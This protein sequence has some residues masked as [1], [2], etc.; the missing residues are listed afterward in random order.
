MDFDED[1]STQRFLALL[2]PVQGRIFAYILSRWPNMADAQDLM[3]ESIATMWEK[4][5]E[6]TPGTDFQAWAIT[7]AKFKVLNFRRK[8]INSPLAFNDQV[9]EILQGKS[10]GFLDKFDDRME[11]LL[12]CVK[13]L[14]TPDRKLVELRYLQE[15]PVSQIAQRYDVSPRMI[16]KTLAR[17]H[18][19]LL[20]CVR[21]NMV[22]EGGC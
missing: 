16:Y 7:I 10:Q 15:Y 8:H 13:K 4:F 20:N 9:L 12:S 18:N 17:I 5:A 1:K 6:Y 11:T 22:R 21:R 3:Q 2:T 14:K 19:S